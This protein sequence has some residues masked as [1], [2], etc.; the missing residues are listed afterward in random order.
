[1]MMLKPSD[2]Q[3]SPDP[4]YTSPSD[5]FQLFSGESLEKLQ[6]FKLKFQTASQLKGGGDGSRGAARNGIEHG[7]TTRRQRARTRTRTR[8]VVYYL[9]LYYSGHWLG[10]I[11]C[12]FLPFFTSTFLLLLCCQQF[13]AA[14]QQMN[15]R[16]MLPDHFPSK[17]QRSSCSFRINI[18][19][20]LQDDVCPWQKGNCELTDNL[21]PPREGQEASECPFSG[22]SGKLSSGCGFGCGWSEVIRRLMNAQELWG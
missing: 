9:W 8:F 12:L 14:N 6:A 21:I 18:I 1:M 10:A 11:F 7:N 3:D 15:C 16:N 20:Q 4:I 5:H 13:A 17:L 2:N 22:E 19:S